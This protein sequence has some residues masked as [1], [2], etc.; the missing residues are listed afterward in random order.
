M[1]KSVFGCDGPLNP[2]VS[3]KGS[4]SSFNKAGR[5]AAAANVALAEKFDLTKT[6]MHHAAAEGWRHI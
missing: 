5:L 1:G 6:G 2:G 3:A 4:A